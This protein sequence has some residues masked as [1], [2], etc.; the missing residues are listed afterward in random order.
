MSTSIAELVQQL[1]LRP[2]QVVRET[3]NGF[4]A[5][6][7]V[8]ENEATTP[9]LAEQVMLQS[10]FNTPFDPIATGTVVAG[11][12]QLPAPIVIDETDLAPE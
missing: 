9:E 10:W 8:L 6:L 4:T 11:A 5:E 3:V 2:G 12:P 1:N 7:R